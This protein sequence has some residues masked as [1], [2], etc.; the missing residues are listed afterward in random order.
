VEGTITKAAHRG[1]NISAP[2]FWNSVSWRARLILAA[3]V[4]CLFA[5]VGVMSLEMH[6]RQVPRHLVVV[7]VLLSGVA[8]IGYATLAVQRRFKY[9]LVLGAVQFVVEWFVAQY[10]QLGASLAG[11]PQALERQLSI[12]AFCAIMGI[13]AAYSLMIHFF[14]I[15][16]SR[17]YKAHA[18]IALAAEIH[19]F[20]VP[21]CQLRLGRFEMYGASVPSGEV[22]GDLVDVV[23]HGDRWTGYVAD[24]SGHGVPSGVLMAMFKTALRGHL[25]ERGSPG[26]LLS[27]VHR[28]LYPLKLGNMFV[29]AGVLQGGQ[30]G[31]VAF[32]LA[33]HPPILHYQKTRGTV[34]EYPPLDLPLGI[35]AEQSFSDSSIE[36]EAGD[37][38]LLL[39]DGFTEIFDK[40]EHEFGMDALKAA[41]QECAG[42]PLADIFRHLRKAT[43]DFG[44]QQDDQ[45]ILLVRYLG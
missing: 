28:T 33:G 17:Y 18:E 27:Q 37:I 30:D 19:G 45:T 40:H 31:R 44:V 1:R 36:C 10:F 15:E 2:N 12:L 23:E 43:A 8:A 20:L 41:F 26:E 21:V 4:F 16:G 11:Q 42:L 6:A 14:R 3:A 22:G 38:L 7:R 25:V 39:T 9:M 35:L 34:Q 32:A 13:I 29:T 24:V 5:S